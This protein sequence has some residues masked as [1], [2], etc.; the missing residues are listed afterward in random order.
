MTIKVRTTDEWSRIAGSS[1]K[2]QI[3]AD[4]K[5]LVALFGEPGE[6]DGYKVQAEWI[7]VLQDEVGDEYVAT[8]YDWKEGEAYWG[9]GDGIPAEQVTEWHIGGH[10]HHGPTLLREYIE[11]KREEQIEQAW[12]NY[13][14]Q[15]ME[16]WDMA[17]LQ[18]DK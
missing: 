11:R 2:S 10:S 15:G 17:W 14:T 9:T 8:I 13:S 5:E 12:S 1:F 7:V 4:Y 3:T 6:G 18:E 16:A